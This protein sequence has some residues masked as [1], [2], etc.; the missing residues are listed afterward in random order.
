MIAALATVVF[1][2]LAWFGVVAL[3]GSVEGGWSRIRAAL[4]GDVRPAIIPVQLRVSARYQ[5]M[6]QPR[7]KI[8]Y[9]Q[10]AAA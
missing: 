8:R 7:P 3:A 5:P 9:Q 2:S 4:R 6:R 1:L 10:R